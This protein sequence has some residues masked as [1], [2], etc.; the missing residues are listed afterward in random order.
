MAL[1][2]VIPGADFSGLGNPR[3][4]SYLEGL[5]AD[6][7]AALYMFE[8]GTVG[9][10]YPGPA[11]DYSGNERAAPLI[12]GGSLFKTAG[13]VANS[14]AA[15]RNAGGGIITPVS[16]TSQFTVF[17]VHRNLIAWDGVLSE[18]YGI[19]WSVSG[20]WPSISAPVMA[21]SQR[22]LVN[23]AGRGGQLHVNQTVAAGASNNRAEFASLSWQNAEAN[24]A[25][26]WAGSVRPSMS[27]AAT[28]KDS[29]I[30]WALSFDRASGYT[31]RA[32]G[33]GHTIDAPVY[34]ETF[35]AA[36]IANGS[37]HIFG[38]VGYG[39]GTFAG[40]MAMAG[41]YTDV[42]MAAADMDALIARMK[43]R[44]AD[45]IATIL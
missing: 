19:H 2:F 24:P 3:V 44:L 18:I 30:A 26:A 29:W 41:V 34:A 42:A 20:N 33:T 12:G 9:E 36:H 15:E 13:G 11:T 6:N 5:P 23:T 40:E 7:L 39:G 17:G 1:K 32:L 28:P 4:Q 27:A 21:G 10:A 35:A 31:L 8:Q 14:L 45:R 38:P 37:K 25:I 16:V 22:G 43:L